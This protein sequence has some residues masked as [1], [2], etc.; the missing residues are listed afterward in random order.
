VLSLVLDPLTHRTAPWLISPCRQ[1]ANH[2][3]LTTGRL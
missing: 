2:A 1:R 3:P